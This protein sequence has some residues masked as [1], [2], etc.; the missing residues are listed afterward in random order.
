MKFEGVKNARVVRVQL[1]NILNLNTLPISLFPAL[2][3]ILS[4][5]YLN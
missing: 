5:E 1:S 4:C 3:E 2:I